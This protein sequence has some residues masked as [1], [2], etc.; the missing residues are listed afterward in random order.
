MTD[1]EHG[2]ARWLA[3]VLTHVS[4]FYFDAGGEKR[5]EL[6]HTGCPEGFEG[7]EYYR[8]GGFQWWYDGQ[9]Q[10]GQVSFFFPSL[11]FFLNKDATVS[12]LNSLPF[13]KWDLMI[14]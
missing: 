12:R 4:A 11:P 10:R 13:L 3:D 5:H 9:Q 6:R 8:N 1:Q 7:T 14:Y 2:L